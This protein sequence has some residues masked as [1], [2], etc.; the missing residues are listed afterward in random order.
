MEAAMPR[1]VLIVEDDPDIAEGLRYNLERERLT[2][3]VADTGEKGL[4]AALDQRNPPLLVLLDIMLP[5]MSGTDSSPA[6]ERRGR[7][8]VGREAR[9]AARSRT[10]RS[11]PAS[12]LSRR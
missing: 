9:A 8:T 6:Q 7:G 3:R 5:G 4:E 1:P 2:V 12:R 11:R 10:T